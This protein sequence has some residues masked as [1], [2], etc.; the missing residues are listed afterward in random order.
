MRIRSKS[1]LA[2]VGLIVALLAPASRIDAQG[3]GPVVVLNEAVVDFPDAVT[4]RLELEAGMSIADAQLTYQVGRDSCIA[5]GTHVPV[6]AEGSTLEWTWVMSRSGNPPPGAQMWWEWTITDTAGNVF[7]T[8]REVLT[9]SDERFD[10]QMITS[11]G[12]S[13]ASPGVSSPI[14][15]YWY[16]GDSVGPVLL[17]AAEDILKQSIKVSPTHPPL[18]DGYASERIVQ[19]ICELFFKQ[20]KEIVS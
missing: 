12:S 7:T 5:A 6:E 8:E 9:F 11:E 20:K 17:E 18:W 14:V 16:E 3:D 10:W 2:L 13:D 1:L 4:F 15:L 19:H